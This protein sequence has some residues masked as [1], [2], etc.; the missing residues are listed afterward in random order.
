[1]RRFLRNT[2]I[3]MTVILVLVLAVAPAFAEGEDNSPPDNEITGGEGTGDGSP[4]TDTGE[5][6]GEDIIG[7]EDD[8][9][10]EGEEPDLL[11][12]PM[13]F[14]AP[15][16]A[17]TSLVASKTAQGYKERLVEYD[18]QVKKSADPESLTLEPGQSGEVTYTI[19]VTKA[20]ASSTDKIGVRGTIT[21]TNSGDR[22]TENLKI[23]DS[24]KYHVIGTYWVTMATVTIIP[25]TQLAPGETRVFNYDMTISPPQWASTFRNE[26]K[27]TITNHS[28]HRGKEF[29]PEPKASFS[30]PKNFTTVEED[31]T[32]TLSDELD[33][34]DGFS[35][36]DSDYDGPCTV[37]GDGTKTIVVQV[38]ND[39]APCGENFDLTNTALLVENDSNDEHEADA[40][41]SIYTGD[42]PEGD[43]SIRVS[44]TAKGFYEKQ[45]EYDW[46]VEKTVDPDYLE[47]GLEESG[48]VTYTINATRTKVSEVV[49]RGVRGKVCVTNTG[50]VPI[51]GLHIVDRVQWSSLGMLWF[52]V[53]GAVQVID[54]DDTIAPGETACFDY[55]IVFTPQWYMNKFKN[56]VTVTI[57]DPEGESKTTTAGFSMPCKASTVYIDREAHV[58]DEFDDAEL[59][60]SVVPGEGYETEGWHFTDS[61]SVS[62][63]ATITNDSV[64]YNDSETLCNTV[65]LVEMD[66]EEE[67]EDDACV[68]VYGGEDPGETTGKVRVEKSG[69]PR[70]GVTFYLYPKNDDVP[71]NGDYLMVEFYMME[72]ETDNNGIVEFDELQPGT[73]ILD[74]ERGNWRSSVRF[75]LEIEVEAGK[76]TLVRVTNTRR[77]SGGGGEEEE[78]ELEEPPATTREPEEQAPPE[79]EVLEV[80]PL[81]DLPK[82][83]G[84]GGI[85]VYLGA[86]LAAL[87]LMMK[88]RVR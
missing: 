19:S 21:V 52:D 65:T 87:G 40:V 35:L 79:V 54:S 59:G 25:D 83:G 61:G 30:I 70:R 23:V 20:Q 39:S 58:T 55:E 68:T 67:D 31:A 43:A 45:I 69:S 51:N 11:M 77:S 34:P 47:L 28:G 3:L 48:D 22:P 2:S 86:G 24:A 6:D 50:D 53:P 27:V 16:Q 38:R 9:G 85:L 57:T 32:A 72:K 81:G 76:T 17:G 66:T 33:I 7:D 62:Y 71:T 73:Y 80:L 10:D 88:R 37:E 29:G 41:V 56:K 15:G 78:E 74:E 60:V 12:A 42:C 82:T 75:P 5:E 1:M 26:A 14:A 64:G 8:E 4:D 44:K 49:S 84:P 13:S 46:E 36:V 18:W 63:S